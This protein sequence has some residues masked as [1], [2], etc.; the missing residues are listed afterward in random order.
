[1]KEKL[2][3]IDGT[4]LLYRAYFAFIRNPLINSKQENT[5]AIF[6]VLN[7]FITL[8]DKMDAAHVAIAFDRK[9][10]TFR[11]QDYEA[12]KANRPPMPDDLQSQIEPVYEFFRL[13]N[14]PQVGADGYEADDALG[15]M[16]ARFCRSF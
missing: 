3:L 4:A 6:G 8:V 15:T 7:S 10:P 14:V 2:Y 12:Y 13:I 9:A 11:H 5:S 1:M 16:G